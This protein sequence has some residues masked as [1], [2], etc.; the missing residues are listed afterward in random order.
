M[1]IERELKPDRFDCS[2]ILMSKNKTWFMQN[3]FQIPSDNK[4]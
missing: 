1:P 3:R 4:K 2:E